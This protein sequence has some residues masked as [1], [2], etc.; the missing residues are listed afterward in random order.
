MKMSESSGQ[1]KADILVTNNVWTKHDSEDSEDTG[2]V[3]MW[4][5]GHTKVESLGCQML[6]PNQFKGMSREFGISRSPWNLKQLL[7]F[8]EGMFVKIEIL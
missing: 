8:H 4:D 5:I 6:A 7:C 1:I 2:V 3:Y